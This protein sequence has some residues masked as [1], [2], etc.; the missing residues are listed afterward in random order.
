MGKVEIAVYDRDRYNLVEE[1][2]VVKLSERE[3]VEIT[4]YHDYANAENSITVSWYAPRIPESL[5]KIFGQ[6]LKNKSKK[7]IRKKVREFIKMLG[8]HKY[9]EKDHLYC[10]IIRN[11]GKETKMIMRLFLLAVSIEELVALIIFSFIASRYPR[12]HLVIS[13]LAVDHDIEIPSIES[14]S[15]SFIRGVVIFNEVLER[16]LRPI[17]ERY[18][19]KYR[20][21]VYPNEKIKPILKLEER[22][23]RWSS[24]VT[25][26]YDDGHINFYVGNDEMTFPSS[27]ND[28]FI[29]I[30]CLED[31]YEEI[32]HV[33]PNNMQKLLKILSS[34]NSVK[35]AE[36]C[37]YML[38]FITASRSREK[39]LEPPIISLEN[40]KQ[41]IQDYIN[42]FDVC[43]KYMKLNKD[44][45]MKG[46][47]LKR[48]RK[49]Q[50]PLE[51][52]ER[53]GNDVLK[54]QYM[55]K[56]AEIAMKMKQK[57][58]FK[59]IYQRLNEKERTMLKLK[60]ISSE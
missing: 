47:L 54:Q 16:Y 58:I 22:F 7:E 9:F 4:Y 56:I 6:H 31:D 49:W 24:K 23:E 26:Y 5:V 44:E 11:F 39:L 35:D 60:F 45:W 41:I 8:L 17:R 15:K 43:Y 37:M 30:E 55:V 10:F 2:Y 27:Q 48:L 25:V 21:G 53:Y 1:K 42:S 18:I 3:E 14:R 36:I 38:H 12:S 46:V 50:R 32:I 34:L 19:R 13:Y 20:V 33:K 52:I 29:I 51:F 28:E 40:M 59:Q 57:E